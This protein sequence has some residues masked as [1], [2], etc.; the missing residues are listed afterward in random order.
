MTFAS[1]GTTEMRETGPLHLADVAGTA[2]G[3]CQI[4]LV[5]D[6]VASRRTGSTHKVYR[7]WRFAVAMDEG[8]PDPGTTLFT[9]PID[10]AQLVA[11]QSRY[12]LVQ[13]PHQG[14]I[15]VGEAAAFSWSTTSI[16]TADPFAAGQDEVRRHLETDGWTQDAMAPACYA[17]P[18][19]ALHGGN[20][21]A[22]LSG[23]ASG[24]AVARF[25]GVIEPVSPELARVFTATTSRPAG[26]G[27]DGWE[28]DGGTCD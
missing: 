8:Q 19:P 6:R 4:R 26:A 28:T 9:V 16:G 1:P 2:W 12:A 22:T 18:D 21:A 24:P 7:G 10:P 27:L 5:A 15:A 23:D 17:K 25:E 11:S 14:L 3:A 13:L 20:T